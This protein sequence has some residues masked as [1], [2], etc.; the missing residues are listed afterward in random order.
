MR[1]V[2]EDDRPGDILAVTVEMMVRLDGSFT[3]SDEDRALQERY[4]ERFPA[5][6]WSAQARTPMGR[7]FPGKHSAYFLES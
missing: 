5:D 4:F 1:F 2:C 7:A 6:H 3:E